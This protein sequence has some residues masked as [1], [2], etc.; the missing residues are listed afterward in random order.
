V[1]CAIY[2]PYT[3]YRYGFKRFLGILKVDGW[4]Y[5]IL[6]F[7]DVQGNYFTVLAYRY[8]V[9]STQSSLFYSANK[10]RTSS[11]PNSSTSGPSSAS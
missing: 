11:P 10:L 1:L 2:T 3:I 9:S 4:K 5:I 7:M 8:T 6:S